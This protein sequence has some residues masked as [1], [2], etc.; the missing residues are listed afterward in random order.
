MKTTILVFLIF[1]TLL[2]TTAF[3][4]T[5]GGKKAPVEGSTKLDFDGDVV[6][7]MNRQPLDSLTSLSE[8]EGGG[9][10]R[11]LYRRKKQIK[12]EN[13]ELAREIFETY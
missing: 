5:K 7:G 8:G 4:K 2:P 9:K 11:Y 6:E 10:R 3:A 1:V 12:P 13:R